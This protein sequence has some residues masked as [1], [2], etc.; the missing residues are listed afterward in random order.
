[1]VVDELPEV[2]GALI[3]GD[4]VLLPVPVVP[5]VLGDCDDGFV[6]PFGVLL[7]SE[8]CGLVLCVCD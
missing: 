8:F 1:V 3:D 2:C 4:C 7:M 6:V 5:L